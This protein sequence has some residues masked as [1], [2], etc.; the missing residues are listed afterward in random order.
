LSYVPGKPEPST[1]TTEGENF[2]AQPTL[3][4]ATSL[5]KTA[6]RKTIGL[7][8]MVQAASV[9]ALRTGQLIWDDL[10]TPGNHSIFQY[11]APT[12]GNI[13]D[14]ASELAWHLTS[15][16]GRGVKGADMG[17]HKVMKL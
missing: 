7:S 14:S 12:P 15:T 6:L 1:L 5:L 3:A 17:L 13:A 4:S 10:S 16:K 8:V 9:Q 11:Y 2:M